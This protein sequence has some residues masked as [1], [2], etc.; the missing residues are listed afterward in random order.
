MVGI[1][2]E[3]CSAERV[4]SCGPINQVFAT[5][6]PCLLLVEAAVVQEPVSCFILSSAVF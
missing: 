6:R 2:Q 1:L 3:I 4:Y 5:L